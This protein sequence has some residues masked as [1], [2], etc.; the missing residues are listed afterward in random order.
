LSF[1]LCHCQFQQTEK[2]TLELDFITAADEDD[3]VFND[4]AWVQT[5]DMNLFVL[6]S[7]IDFK[8]AIVDMSSSPPSV[9]YV[10]LSDMAWPEDA[11]ARDRQVEWA[12]GTDYVWIGGRMELQSYVVDV[13]NKELVQTIKHAGELYK[14]LSVHNRAFTYLADSLNIH[15][16]ETGVSSSSSALRSNGDGSSNGLSIAALAL[17]CIALVAVLTNFIMSMSKKTQASDETLAGKKSEMP[18]SVA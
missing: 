18:P 15:W 2:Q 4:F 10:T 3:S 13:R 12:E 1:S 11:D 5:E 14:M 8:V 17:S 6:A 16:D 7:A 9:S